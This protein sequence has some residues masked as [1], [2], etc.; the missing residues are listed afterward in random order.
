VLLNREWRKR[1]LDRRLRT[2]SPLI[3]VKA[4]TTAARGMWFGQFGFLVALA[5]LITTIILQVLKDTGLSVAIATLV[6]W[7]VG[8]YCFARYL[9][10]IFRASRQ[11][12]QFAGTSPKARAPVRNVRAFQLWRAKSRYAKTSSGWQRDPPL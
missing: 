4:T 7:P 8:I 2:W 12:G 5:W 1:D 3:G 9:R 11:G 10:L 6:A